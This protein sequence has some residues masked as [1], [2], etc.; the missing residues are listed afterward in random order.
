MARAITYLTEH[1]SA[2]PEELASHVFGGVAFTPL[3]NTLQDERLV[4][5]GT[6]WHLAAPSGEWAVVEVLTTGPNPA[7]HRIVEVAAQRNGRRFQALIASDKPTPKLLR[8]LGLPEQSD[9]EDWLSLEEAGQVLRVFLG[10]A[11]AV[12]F[13]YVPEFLAQLLGPC[14]PAV[15][16]LRLVQDSGF[17]GRPDPN[18][19]A[20]ELA[21]PAPINRRP[22][23]M[24]TFSAALFERLRSDRS[25]AELRELARPRRFAVPETPA[26]PNRPGVYVMA[27]PRGRP[28][29]VG[30]SVDLRRRVSSYLRTPI[31]LTRNMHDLMQLTGRIE[32]VPVNSELEA[33]LLE[34]RLIREWQPPFNVQR[35]TGLRR[36]YLRL[37][38][39]EPFPRLTLAAEPAGDGAVYFG[40]FRHAT[41]A[42]RLFG[43]L[44]HLV[45]LRTCSRRLPP[46]RKPRPA[47]AKAATGECLAPC[48]V[49]P[50]PAPYYAEVELARQLLAASPDEFRRLLRRL[51][52]ERPPAPDLARRLKQRVLRTRAES[53]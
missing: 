32:V 38:V 2:S 47:C 37:T 1:G 33:L 30:K 5:D 17:H 8:R 25:L 19:L 43:L 40:P 53:G 4:F 7:R 22:A 24:L 14:W 15:D 34:D 11:T 10:G 16:L 51:L 52:R 18:H 46:V 45:R 9:G 50:P 49:G 28:L 3:L 13:G 12:G 26:L 6:T 44:Q 48:V 20:H 27:E 41:A 36:R 31:E 21:L 29:Y 23:A 35:R 39:A 42:S